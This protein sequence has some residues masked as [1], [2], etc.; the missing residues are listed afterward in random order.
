MVKLTQIEQQMLSVDLPRGSAMLAEKHAH[1][2]NSIHE[3]TL[4]ALHQGRVLLERVGRDE[5]GAEGVRQKVR[6]VSEE[7]SVE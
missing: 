6:L 3:I 5:P 1:L 2:S 7:N 4:P